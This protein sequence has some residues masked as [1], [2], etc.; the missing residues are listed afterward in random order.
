MD[1][2]ILTTKSVIVG[3][4]LLKCLE[5]NM[6]WARMQFKPAKSRSLVIKRGKVIDKHRFSG[7]GTNTPTL[8]ENP[9]KFFGKTLK[10]SLKDTIPIHKTIDDQNE[11]MAKT[12]KS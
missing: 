10:S 12:E 9:I 2:L 8:T 3:K 6:V 1:D 5:R 11:A 4:W 7:A